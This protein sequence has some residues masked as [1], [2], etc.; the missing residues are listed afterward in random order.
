MAS[1][2]CPTLSLEQRARALEFLVHLVGDLHQPLHAMEDERGANG[3]EVTIVTQEGCMA[4]CR[5]TPI[6]TRPGTRR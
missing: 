4:T 2:A 6:C 3:V 5:S 1:V